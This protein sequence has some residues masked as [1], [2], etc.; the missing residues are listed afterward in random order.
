MT[1]FARFVGWY[2]H[3]TDRLGAA[4]LRRMFPDDVDEQDQ[5]DE[6]ERIR[7]ITD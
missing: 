5:R 4:A 3:W 6:L 1:T 7:R 2:D